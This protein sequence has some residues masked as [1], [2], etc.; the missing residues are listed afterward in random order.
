MDSFFP[1]SRP[2]RCFEEEEAHDEKLIKTSYERRGSRRRKLNEKRTGEGGRTR[3]EPGYKGRSM[4]TLDRK[5]LTIMLNGD[6][7][8]ASRLLSSKGINAPSDPDYKD[9]LQA[10]HVVSIVIIV[11]AF[12]LFRYF[13]PFF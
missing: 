9:T 4:E 12:R 13:I 11:V 1:Y 10:L 7:R 2:P 8:K 3:G 6:Q 5:T